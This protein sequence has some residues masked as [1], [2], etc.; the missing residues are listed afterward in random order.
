MGNL[1]FGRL[2]PGGVP[3][4]YSL[5]HLLLGLLAEALVRVTAVSKGSNLD[6]GLQTNKKNYTGLEKNVMSYYV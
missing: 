4:F 3:T 5:P 1:V 6:I 2:Y